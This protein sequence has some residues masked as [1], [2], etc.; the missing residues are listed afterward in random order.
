[1]TDSLI[2][3][4]LQYVGMEKVSLKNGKVTKKHPEIKLDVNA[5]AQGYSVDVMAGFLE[6]RGVKHFL[7]EIGGEVKARGKNPAGKYWQIGVDSPA[8]NNYQPG[9][10]LQNIVTLKNKALATS[11]NYRKFYT[12]HGIKYT[13]SINPKTGQTVSHELLSATI[14]TDRCITAD[15]LATCCMVMGPQKAKELINALPNVEAY[16]ILNNNQGGYATWQ[17]SARACLGTNAVINSKPQTANQ[18]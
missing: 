9:K 7:V 5:L 17:S 18:K 11:G 2:D 15:A 10:D 13:H 8:E 16:F 6:Q 1:M 14:V 3:S 4:L 12:E